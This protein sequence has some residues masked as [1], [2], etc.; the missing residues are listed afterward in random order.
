MVD[1]YW[2]IKQQGKF[3]PLFT[4]IEGI[5]IIIVFLVYTTQVNS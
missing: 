4:D 3:L 1:V 5:M 2:A